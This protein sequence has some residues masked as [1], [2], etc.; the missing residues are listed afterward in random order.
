MLTQQQIDTLNKSYDSLFDQTFKSHSIDVN[1]STEDH[2]IQ[3][4]MVTASL[5]I[6]REDIE[7]YG[8]KESWIKKYLANALAKE[9]IENRLVEFTR[10]EDLVNGN[11]VFRARLFATPD[12]SVR[13]LRKTMKV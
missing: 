3:G 10:Q 13:L 9:L 7:D 12:T 1:I 8:T 2:A 5:P 4:K 6:A 11:Y